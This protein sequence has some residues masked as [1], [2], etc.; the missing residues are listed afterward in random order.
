VTDR[1]AS[2]DRSGS[3]M[4]GLGYTAREAARLDL[5][6]RR[7]DDLSSALPQ[8][9]A[10]ATV[11][12]T[13]AKSPRQVAVGY[14]STV[15]PHEAL[16][17]SPWRWKVHIA[18]NLV[19]RAGFEP[20]TRC[21]EG[22]IFVLLGVAE[23][24]LTGSPTAQTVAWRSPICAPAYG[25]SPLVKSAAPSARNAHADASTPTKT[26]HRAR[27][28][29]VKITLTSKRRVSTP[30]SPYKGQQINR[31]NRLDTESSKEKLS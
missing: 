12:P 17:C 27:R 14:E 31:S 10:T 21:L 18:T 15:K 25:P 3:A 29:T 28:F 9:E 13:C 1:K 6:R 7:R 22:T 5:G 26:S 16:L 19:R 24:R 20:A 4:C 11:R 8:R 23:Y 30:V 2:A